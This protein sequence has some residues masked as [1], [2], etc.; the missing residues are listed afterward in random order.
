[1][2]KG[3]KCPTR[4]QIAATSQKHARPPLTT[5]WVG[6]LESDHTSHTQ[7]AYKLKQTQCAVL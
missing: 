5:C 7:C 1:M 3:R 4:L 2:S 6:V